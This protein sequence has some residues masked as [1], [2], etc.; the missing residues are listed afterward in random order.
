MAEAFFVAFK[1]PNFF[2]RLFG[3][4]A[5]NAAFV[6]MFSYK[7]AEGGR[8]EALS[9]G[10][11]IFMVLLSALLVFCML[12]E[13]FMPVVMVV[14]APGFLDD[15][16]QFNLAVTLTRITFPYL[17]FISLVSLLSGMLNS[18]HKFVAGA[19]APILLNL[20]LILGLLLYDFTSLTA[21]HV[22]SIAVAI[23][24]IV[25][26]L[27]LLYFCKKNGMTFNLFKPKLTPDT[28]EFL[29]KLVPGVI[30]AG[31][32]QINLWVDIII[33]TFLP[34]AIAYLYYADRVNQLPLSIIGIALGT[35]MLPMLSKYFRKGEVEEAIHCQNRALEMALFLTIPAM[36]AFL[37][38]AEPVVQVLFERGEFTAQNTLA[39][40]YALMAYALG[41]P[42]FVMVKIFT[43]AFFAQGD[44]KTPVRIAIYAL[45]LNVILNVFFVFLF[46]NMGIMPHI[47]LALATSISSWFNL[48]ILFNLLIKNNKYRIENKTIS[49]ILKIIISSIIMAICLMFMRYNMDISVSSLIIMIAVGKIS[50]MMC[51]FATKAITMEDLRRLRKKA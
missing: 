12:M 33:A 44:T 39:T 3:E 24:G 34:G 1:L 28:K 46:Q 25:Q 29:R 9:F 10:R 36:V 8:E 5:F 21:A 47:G 30:G 4:G 41:L 22:A 19:S 27:W 49:R 45:I 16:K 18:V 15:E 40:S 37:V 20:C 32:M 13:I 6:P 50:Y 11:N 42:A 7:L 26:F 48:T 35:A 31:V 38:I 2:R 23:A 43:P 17:L 51:A 14:L